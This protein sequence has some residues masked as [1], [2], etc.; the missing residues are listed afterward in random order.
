MQPVLRLRLMLSSHHTRSRISDAMP[1][2][3]FDA[4]QRRRSITIPAL[5]DEFIANRRAKGK[6]AGYL[7]DLRARLGRFKTSMSERI[8]A[9]LTTRDIDHWIQSLNVGPQTQNNFRAVLSTAWTL[10]V[11]HGY[12][13]RKYCSVGG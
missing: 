3:V 1:E 12:A 13:S 7:R 6:S 4:E 10:A 5:I 9:E 11:R 2:Y 8:V